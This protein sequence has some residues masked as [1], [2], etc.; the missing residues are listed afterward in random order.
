VGEWGDSPSYPKGEIK[1]KNATQIEA[2]H[3]EM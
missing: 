3:K 1:N 2:M